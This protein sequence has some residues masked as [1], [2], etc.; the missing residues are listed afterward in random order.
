MLT[1]AAGSPALDLE[2]YLRRLGAERPSAPDAEA[3]S[4]LHEAHLLAVPFE[5]LSIIWGEPIVLD[6]E[7]I[8]RKVVGARRGGGCLELNALF[9][10][11]LRALGFEVDLLSARVR[12][13]QGDFGPDFDHLCLRVRAGEEAWL[14]DVG[15]GDSFRRP[16][17][18]AAAGVHVEGRRAYALRQA[19]EELELVRREAEGPWEPQ[20]RFSQVPRRLEEFAGMSAYHQSAP[21]G[22]FTQRR[23]CSIA[24]ADGRVTLAERSLVRTTLEGGRTETPIPDESA[25]A[26]ALRTHFGIRPPDRPAA[27]VRSPPSRV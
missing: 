18:L 5:N 19:A 7:A 20:Y 9:A 1:R 15:F 26:H 25:W 17:R 14:A 13:E 8:F 11:A 22:P 27:S 6:E 3:L 16:L 2:R 10:W 23:L 4:R 12:R 21:G 24:T